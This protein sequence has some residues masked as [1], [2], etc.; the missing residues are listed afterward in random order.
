MLRS[1]VFALAAAVCSSVG[2]A[3]NP[4][5]GKIT[6]QDNVLPIFRTHCANCHNPDKTRG[7]LNVATFAA[8]MAGGSSGQVVEAGNADNS[9]IIKLMTHAEEPKMPPKGT[10][11]PDKEIE[12]V[13]RWIEGGL[14]ETASSA[15]KA[16]KKPAVSLAL[17]APATGKPQGP[18]PMPTRPLLQESWFRTA[19]PGTVTAMASSPWAPLFAL[20]APHQVLL[21]HS[22]SLELVGVLLRRYAARPEFSQNARCSGGRRSRWQISKVIVWKV[23]TGERQISRR[24][25]R[26]R[27]CCRH[28]SDQTMAGLRATLGHHST[29]MASQSTPLKSTPNG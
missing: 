2:F 28:Q 21:Y 3:A 18:P 17:S 7:D 22:D 26:R 10:K 6:F 12:I 13:R 5:G 27:P 23:G 25:V 9:R 16:G 15:A 11:V 24:R 8:L 20:G 1:S 29:R 19:K 4:P 14:L